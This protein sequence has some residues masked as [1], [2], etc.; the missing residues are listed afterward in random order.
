MMLCALALLTLVPVITGDNAGVKVSIT[1]RGLDYAVTNTIKQV[2]L[3]M[4]IPDH[5]GTIQ[6]LWINF[7]YSFT[8]MKIH[9][10]NFKSEQKFVSGT[11][12]SIAVQITN[13]NVSGYVT[14][15]RNR[16]F[17]LFVTTLSISATVAVKSDRNGHP[18]LNMNEDNCLPEIGRF[19]PQ[20]GNRRSINWILR[21]I[22][23]LFNGFVRTHLKNQICNKLQTLLADL[24][25]QLKTLKA[26]VSEYAEI[27]YSLRSPVVFDNSIEMGLKGV[28]YNTQQRVEPPSSPPAFSLAS[29]NTNMFYIAVSAFTINSAFMVL[30]RTN[31]FNIR[32][33]DDMVPSVSPIRLSTT[34]FGAFIPQISETHPDLKLE[35]KVKTVKEPII[36]FEP[37]HVILQLL[38]TVTAYDVQ[39]GNTPTQ[40]FVLNLESVASVQ[41]SVEE[42]DLAL[43]LTLEK[44]EGSMNGKPFKVEK[45][46]FLTVIMH[47]IVFPIIKAHL[48]KGLQPPGLLGSYI[49]KVHVVKPQ[50]KVLNDYVLI[51]TDIEFEE[52]TSS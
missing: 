43:D 16:T 48:A 38:S 42:G 1:Q 11:G 10:D 17:E 27:D 36:K 22:T 46:H 31:V 9:F 15:G 34:T 51:G 45:T 13:L 52:N 30:H 32:I 3:K 19:K 21:K 8:G 29:Q 25:T 6:V 41:V 35:L 49:G 28:F 2:L 20:I 18:I 33:T 5:F 23:S 26:K 4:D 39:S 50:V 44:I 14:L 47:N 7:D 12:V 24:N 37:N 40:L